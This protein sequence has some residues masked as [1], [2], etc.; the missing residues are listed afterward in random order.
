M[1]T[2]RP[3]R[4][5][6]SSPSARR[7]TREHTSSRKVRSRTPYSNSLASC[8]SDRV[9]LARFSSCHVP[10]ATKLTNPPYSPEIFAQVT[11]INRSDKPSTTD[12]SRSVS[13]KRELEAVGTRVIHGWAAGR[14]REPSEWKRRRED[15]KGNHAHTRA[16]I[17][18]H[19]HTR[20]IA[21]SNDCSARSS[22]H[23]K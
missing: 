15:E 4:A 12:T 5:R 8:S 11:I 19:A 16:L 22:Q 2:S 7:R 14:E 9:P 21:H 3:P 13:L 20:A 10:D 1:R 18:P 17:L 6:G 23:S